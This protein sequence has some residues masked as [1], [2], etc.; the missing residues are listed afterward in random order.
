MAPV[1]FIRLY[2]RTCLL[3]LLRYGLAIFLNLMRSQ[4]GPRNILIRQ[5]SA[6]DKVPLKV[7]T[8]G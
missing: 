2:I 8:S 1:K 6:F 3:S 7:K 4:R 5:D